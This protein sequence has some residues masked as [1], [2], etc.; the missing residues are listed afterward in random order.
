MLLLMPVSRPR[1]FLAKTIAMLIPVLPITLLLMVGMLWVVG[2]WTAFVG[3][4]VSFGSMA[5]AVG[6]ALLLLVGYRF[7]KK[8]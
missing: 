8:A 1:I 3:V 5:I 6:G 4:V 7:L 2:G